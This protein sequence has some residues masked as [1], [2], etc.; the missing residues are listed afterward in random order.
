[1]KTVHIAKCSCGWVGAAEGGT[2][3]VN[4]FCPQ[5]GTGKYL[6]SI[7]DYVLASEANEQD[8]WNVK[9]TKSPGGG[10][11]SVDRYDLVGEYDVGIEI[12]SEGD[13]VW[14]EDSQLLKSRV[15]ELEAEVARLTALVQEHQ[16]YQTKQGVK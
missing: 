12:Q 1:M 16:T 8:D 15:R 11:V 13:Y 3:I 10:T 7:G 9:N 4:Y 5:C 6:V 2:K 14:Y